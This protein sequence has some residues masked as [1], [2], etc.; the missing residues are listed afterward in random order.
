MKKYKSL[1]KACLS[2]DMDIF[3][4][5]TKSQNKVSKL[6]LPIF[7]AVIIMFAVGSYVDI[8]IEPLLPTNN[9]F[10][11]LSLFVFVSFFLTLIEGV[12]K[13]SAILFN[14]KDDDLLLSLP[15]SRRSILFVRL[16]KFYLFELLYNTIFLLPVIVVYAYYVPVGFSYYLVSLFM[17]ILLP[18]IPIVLSC[19]LGIIASSI[20]SRFKRKNLFQIIISLIF[21]GVIIFLSSNIDQYISNFAEKATSINEIITKIYYPAGLYAT[22]V[23]KFNIIELIIFIIINIGLFSGLII[24]FSK[25]YFKVNTRSKS[26]SVHKNGKVV[27]IRKKKVVSSIVNKEIKRILSTPVLVINAV[28]G[29]LLFIIGIIAIVYKFDSLLEMILKQGNQIGSSVSKE[30]IISYIPLINIALILFGSFTSSITSSLISLEGKSFAI[31][32][33]MPIQPIKVIIGKVYAAIIVMLPIILLGDIIMIVYFNYN[34]LTILIILLASLIIP[35]VAETRGI[36]I[37]LKYPKMNGTNDT[38]IVKQSVSAFIAVL[39]GFGIIILT[40]MLGVKLL[41]SDVDKYIIMI[42]VLILFSIIFGLFYIYLK[43]KGTEDYN[44]ICV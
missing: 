6:L 17:L 32:K 44:K 25:F 39:L 43:K 12:Y 36:I 34:L 7:L 42:G 24:G 28:S 4:L 30:L 9:G 1:I 8:L 41:V 21:L 10:I 14:C 29:L 19:I 40:I 18:I 38:E 35:M 15:L 31:L 3:K 26:V 16:F 27:R 5:N 20:S 23:T 22:L 11:V 2:N 33:T 37:N 13:S